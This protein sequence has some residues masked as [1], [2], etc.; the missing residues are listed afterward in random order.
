MFAATW[1]QQG[2]VV[3]SAALKSMAIKLSKIA[4]D[5]ILLTSGPRAGLKEIDLP[6]MQPGLDHARQG[7]SGD[8]GACERHRV[9]R[10]R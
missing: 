7:Q 5:L 2:F 6:A 4:S 9:P 10:D 3:Y 1:E 8:A